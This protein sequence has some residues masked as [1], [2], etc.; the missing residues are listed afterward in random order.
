MKKKKNG[1]LKR[2]RESKEKITRTRDPL[3]LI[4][5]SHRCLKA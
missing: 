2:K 5:L 3:P 4:H 1:Q